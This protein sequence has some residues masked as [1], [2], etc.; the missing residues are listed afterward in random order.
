MWLVGWKRMTAIEGRENGGKK[1]ERRDEEERGRRPMYNTRASA[2]LVPLV[3][4][5][6]LRRLAP[7]LVG[8]G[9]RY[10]GARPN[11]TL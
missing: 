4:Y 5:K 2:L 3:H 11:C 9:V 6:T 10:K 7:L 1:K 8:P